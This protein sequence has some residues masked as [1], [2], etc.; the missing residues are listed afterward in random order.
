M[1][2][3]PAL[4]TTAVRLQ[5]SSNPTSIADMVF[6]APRPTGMN[7]RPIAHPAEWI[8]WLLRDAELVNLEI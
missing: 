1:M 8:R 7:H 5:A 3:A 2:T 4:P 6:I